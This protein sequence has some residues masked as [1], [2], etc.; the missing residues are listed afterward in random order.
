VSHSETS[1]C[2]SGEGSLGH[3]DLIVICHCC[4]LNVGAGVAAAGAAVHLVAV[5]VA[6]VARAGG[7]VAKSCEGCLKTFR[8]KYSNPL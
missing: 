6:A 3:C 5:A 1:N 7:V 8:M 4:P 2:L